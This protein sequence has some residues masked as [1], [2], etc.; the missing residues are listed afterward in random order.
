M[1]TRKES[2]YDFWMAL[3]RETKFKEKIRP[4][5][6]ALPN[7]WVVKIQQQAI[8]GTPDLI[9]CIRGKFVALELKRCTKSKPD[10]LQ[11]YTL[12]KI[13]DAGG[14]GLVVS[15]ENWKETFNFLREIAMAPFKSKAQ[16]AKLAQMVKEGKFP[17]E[18]FDEFAKA[19][20]DE[21]A[22]PERV[23]PAKPTGLD[24]LKKVKKI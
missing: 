19:T 7:T 10:R 9:L 20:P 13:I 21:K 24:R 14:I 5:L 2:Q 4:I 11:E 22:L 23:G 15:P 18:K 8:R 1:H 16:R 12:N 3:Q 6:E 17:Q